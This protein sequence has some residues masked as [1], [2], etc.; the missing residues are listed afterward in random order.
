MSTDVRINAK[1]DIAVGVG[2]NEISIVP[3]GQPGQ[4][5]TADPTRLPGVSWQDSAGGSAIVHTNTGPFIGTFGPCGNAGT[6]TVCPEAFRV[7]VAASAGAVLDWR[8][9][10]VLGAVTNSADAEFDLAAV[11]NSV[12]GAPV[13]LRCLSSGTDT[14]LT[15]GMG[16]MYCWANNARRLPAEQWETQ[17]GDIIG[18]TVTL[19][20]LY[21]ANATGLSVGHGSVYPN[22]VTLT[23]IGGTP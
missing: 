22:R 1:G 15:N 3:I 16:S 10:A 20:L 23:N 7:A 4:V 11:D 13:I 18:G 8:F 12:P 2:D 19:A 17:A 9:G 6:W 21:R 14:P 5:L